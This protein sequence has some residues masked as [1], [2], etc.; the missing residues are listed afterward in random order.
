M[1]FSEDTSQAKAASSAPPP[2]V[3]RPELPPRSNVGVSDIP[4]LSAH[5]LNS[6]LNVPPPPQR[7][8]TSFGGEDI[9][10]PIHYT[11]DPHRLVA[12]LVPFP[13]PKLAEASAKPDIPE[14]F[15]IYTPPPPPLSKPEQNQQEGHV[16][17]V[18]RKWEEEIREAKTSDAKTMSWKGLKGKA[19]KGINWGISQTKTSNAEFL[20]RM[21]PSGGNDEHDD[22]RAEESH[23]DENTK[24]TVKLEELM[25]VYPS[26]MPKDPDQLRQEFVNTMLRSKSK[27]EKDAIIA[28][29]LLP[30]S[31]AIDT[32]ATLIWP[33]GGLLEI[34]AVWAYA[35]IRGAKTSRSV[36]KR[37]ASTSE[38]GNR[39]EDKLT[40]SFTPS[41]RLAL[42]EK[43]LAARC[44]E[45]EPK[46]FPFIAAAPTET[47]IL[48]TIGW[49]P[50]QT[51]P[52][53]N[54]E[55]E[56]WEVSEVKED[57]QSVMA[58]GAKEWG[59]W[60]HAFEKEPEK[61]LKK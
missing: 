42:L 31:F 60:C 23:E 6:S 44:H 40:L 36:T 46:L 22:N 27:A 38:T 54:W 51:G 18:Q 33:F 12:Y 41:E 20:N 24:P 26:S 58:K 2:D 32:L 61:A 3:E 16:H 55:D 59:K 57:L 17:K 45:R 49:S 13:K 48:E 37:L 7:K 47:E 4:G 39:D 29:G 10:S 28:T 14:R 5:S 30:V 50:S 56:A 35:S 11:R 53:K 15:L 34:D 43:Y 21:T 52:K 8:R 9:A 1:S 25:L 19:T